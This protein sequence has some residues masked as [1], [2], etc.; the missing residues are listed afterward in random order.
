MASEQH[1]RDVNVFSLEILI[2]SFEI[3]DIDCLQ[4]L[5]TNIQFTIRQKEEQIHVLMIANSNH[6]N[7]IEIKRVYF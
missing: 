2:Y 1:G 6:K 3:N 5:Y 7:G 4:L